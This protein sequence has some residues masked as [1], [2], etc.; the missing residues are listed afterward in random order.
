[1]AY[2]SGERAL[3]CVAAYKLQSKGNRNIPTYDH[4][5]RWPW[6]SAL[7]IIANEPEWILLVWWKGESLQ[8]RLLMMTL[9]CALS[10][11]LLA[12]QL[13]WS[14]NYLFGRF[15]FYPPNWAPFPNQLNC[16]I[17]GVLGPERCCCHCHLQNLESPS[18]LDLI[19]SLSPA[20]IKEDAIIRIEYRTFQILLILA[21][22]RLIHSLGISN[23]NTHTTRLRNWWPIKLS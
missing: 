23:S 5:P 8:W 19:I 18:S 2:D 12:P 1:M 16:E 3:W 15:Q 13:I 10:G 4:V 17:S 11:L 6:F 20:N 14:F 7:R 9:R 21:R 22:N